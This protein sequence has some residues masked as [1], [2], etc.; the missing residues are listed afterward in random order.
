VSRSV[1]LTLAAGLLAAV[2]SPLAAHA[3]PPDPNAYIPYS[4]SIT[5]IPIAQ[6]TPNLPP[7]TIYYPQIRCYG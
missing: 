7:V 1:R 4:C 5:W 2:A 6:T 3:A